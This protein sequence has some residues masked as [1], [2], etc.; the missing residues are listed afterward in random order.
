MSHCEPERGNSRL[1]GVES[2]TPFPPITK[3]WLLSRGLAEEGLEIGAG[4]PSIDE[5][6]APNRCAL[7]N[8]QYFNVCPDCADQLHITVRKSK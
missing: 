2:E 1:D 3:E 7:H 4:A 6:Y 5:G 8:T